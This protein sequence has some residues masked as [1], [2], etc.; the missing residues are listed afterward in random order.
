EPEAGDLLAGGFG[1]EGIGG[2][3]GQRAT[4]VGHNRAGFTVTLDGGAELAGE[5]LLGATRRRPDLAAVRRRAVGLARDPEAI[6][7]AGHLRA[8]PG[9]W[10]LG[11]ITGQGAFT[12]MSTYQA[13]IVVADILGEPGFAAQYHAVP[14][15]TFTDPEVGAVGLTETQARDQGLDVLV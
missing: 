13:R 14:R 2:H 3:T 10:A 15:V 9:V 5:A 12:H 4:G 6:P 1:R 11:D 8:A 7:V